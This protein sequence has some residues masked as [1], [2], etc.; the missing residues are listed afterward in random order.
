MSRV[1]SVGPPNNAIQKTYK[2]GFDRYPPKSN[3][4]KGWRG[5]LLPP[6]VCVVRGGCSVQL[7]VCVGAVFGGAASGCAGFD[8]VY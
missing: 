2:S 4:S 1:L 7:R 3:L 8:A 5:F 6:R